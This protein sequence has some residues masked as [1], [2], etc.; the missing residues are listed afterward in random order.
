MRGPQTLDLVVLVPDR[1]Y[2]I[3][4]EPLLRRPEA[5]GIREIAFE[6]V[7]HPRHDPGC[8]FESVPLLSL[9]QSKAAHALVLYDREGGWS[10]EL[11]STDL[12][13]ETLAALSNAGWA[14]RAGCVVVDPE[15]E[16][17]VWSDSPVVDQVLGWDGRTPGLRSWLQA[18]G[19]LAAGAAKPSR[20]KEAFRAAVLEAGRK[21]S[22]SLF[23]ALARDVSFRRCVDPAF[24]R[25]CELLQ[26]WFPAR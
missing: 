11:T 3:V 12:E 22:S 15:L 25:L 20:P 1:A 5:L 8:R 2:V 10:A 13:R 9:Y 18:R 26:H 7:A 19:W 6:V 14:D 4:L 17:W 21:P 16:A 24:C 23:G